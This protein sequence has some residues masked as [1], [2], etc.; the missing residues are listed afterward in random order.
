MAGLDADALLEMTDAS[1]IE[2]VQWTG[3]QRHSDERGVL[4]P[5]TE[6]KRPALADVWQVSKYPE[7]WVRQVQGPESI[8]YR[9]IG[10]AEAL[11]AKAEELGQAWMT[12]VARHIAGKTLRERPT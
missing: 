3:D 10:S 8:Y 2:L 9:A 11:M 7:E 1:D 12:G 4:E 5:I 6:S